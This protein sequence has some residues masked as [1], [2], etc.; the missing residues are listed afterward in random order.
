MEKRSIMGIL[1]ATDSQKAWAYVDSD[2]QIHFEQ[3]H[4]LSRV[5]RALFS[6]LGL[7]N[8]DLSAVLP[9]LQ[10]MPNS[11]D[12]TANVKYV[13]EKLA[14]RS[15]L[16]T[17]DLAHLK[18]L[19]SKTPATK[20]TRRFVEGS[21]GNQKLNKALIAFRSQLQDD[22]LIDRKMLATLDT[23]SYKTR[24]TAAL[25][26]ALKKVK[27]IQPML[28]KQG[29][30]GTL[31]EEEKLTHCDLIVMEDMAKLAPMMRQFK[32]MGLTSSKDTPLGALARK[33]NRTAN[34]VNQVHNIAERQA[35]H[36]KGG[37]LIFYDIHN[38]E[39]KR[40]YWCKLFDKV[41]FKILFQTPFFHA[42]V[43]YK[44]EKGQDIEADVWARFRQMRRTLYSRTFKTFEFNYD[45]LAR[46]KETRARLEKLYGNN[47]QRALE[48]KFQRKLQAYFK[49]TKPYSHLY[50]PLLRRFLT[51]MGLRY[52]PF[53]KDLLKK[54][55]FGKESVCSEFA[56]KSLMQCFMELQAEI[57]QDWNKSK[58]TPE[59]QEAPKLEHPISP[60]RR[61]HRVTPKDMVE[62]LLKTGFAQEAKRPQIIHDIIQFH[63]F[64]LPKS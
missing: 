54:I 30:E 32:K 17:S 64:D 40:S 49:N 1:A 26:Q 53:Q 51:G 33:I 6:L 61:L 31:K 13:F 42:S 23:F 28:R 63:D 20:E 47:W 34:F 48:A 41:V 58:R 50:N 55:Q 57:N 9:A 8:Y 52:N 12:Q 2:K 38:F 25:D 43:G 35:P 10:A 56:T 36:S 46:N 3:N 22:S 19:C 59:G 37:N 18:T 24:P 5:V 29:V 7:R 27:K 62:K 21:I 44:N 11:P 14:S 4:F 15:G 45:R 16:S 60:S 39:A